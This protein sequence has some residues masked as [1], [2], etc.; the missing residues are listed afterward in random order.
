MFWLDLMKKMIV[1]LGG[2][3]INQINLIDFLVSILSL[4]KVFQSG[5]TTVGFK[6]FSRIGMTTVG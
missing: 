5:M 2:V 6:K 3:L 4:S 1:H